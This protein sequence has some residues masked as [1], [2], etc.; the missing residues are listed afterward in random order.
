VHVGGDFTSI[1]G[2]PLKDYALLDPA[3]GS[4]LSLPIVSGP[5]DDVTTISAA[6][7]DIYIGGWFRQIAGVPSSGI[8]GIVTGVVAVP[9]PQAPRS[10]GVELGRASPD[11]RAWPR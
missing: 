8:A 9:S 4:A 11:P 10:D 7:D 2:Q 5:T 6:G 1:S 3:T